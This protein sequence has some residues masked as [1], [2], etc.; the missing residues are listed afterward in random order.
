MLVLLLEHAACEGL[1]LRALAALDIVVILINMV[2]HY[3]TSPERQ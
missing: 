1:F 2:A 3:T